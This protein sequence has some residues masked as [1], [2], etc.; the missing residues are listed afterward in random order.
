[1]AEERD[2]LPEFIGHDRRRGMRTLFLEYEVSMISCVL[3]RNPAPWSLKWRKVPNSFL[4]FPSLGKLRVR[5]TTGEYLVTAGEFL[6]LPE[7]VGHAIE[8]VGNYRRLEQFS[9]HCHIQDRW[10]RPF[11]SRLA[12]PVGKLPERTTWTEALGE[13]VCLMTNDRETGAVRGA[14]F[15]RELLAWQLARQPLAQREQAGDPRVRIVI[16]DME[17]NLHSPMI[18]IESLADAVHITSTQLRTIFRRDTGRS[19][20]GFLNDLRLRKASQLLR[21]SAASVKE[22]A[23][24]CGFGSDHYFHLVFR[25]AFGCTPS[26]Y[27]RT[28][29]T[30]V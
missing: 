9:L 28:A 18:S 30:R 16:E 2:D 1:M 25:K 13:L 11:L 14:A 8:L 5:L 26:E 15:V 21:H 7:N 12:D 29:E 20:L 6:M 17:R 4:L 10:G 23:A 24:D 19:P 3:W 27:R 22:I